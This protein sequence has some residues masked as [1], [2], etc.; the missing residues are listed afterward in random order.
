M[1]TKQLDI[2]FKSSFSS[3][4][5]IVRVVFQTLA[6]LNVILLKTLKIKKDTSN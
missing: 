1:R 2:R 5:F 3:R 4:W 6:Y